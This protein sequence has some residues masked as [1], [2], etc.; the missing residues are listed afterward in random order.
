MLHHYLKVGEAEDDLQDLS[1][2]VVPI[3]KNAYHDHL[4]DML[5]FYLP[6][7]SRWRLSQRQNDKYA[8]EHVLAEARKFEGQEGLDG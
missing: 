4:E 3:E 2:K 7:V 1:L 5:T 6:I 8:E